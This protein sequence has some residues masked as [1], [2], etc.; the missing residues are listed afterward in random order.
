MRDFVG[1]EGLLAFLFVM[2]NAW[3]VGFLLMYLE[4]QQAKAS[5]LYSARLISSDLTNPLP[6]GG[7]L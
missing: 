6:D 2:M 7:L 3:E 4:T 5:K 1:L